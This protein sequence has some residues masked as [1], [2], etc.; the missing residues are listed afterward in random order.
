MVPATTI[1]PSACS[2]GALIEVA[3]PAATVITS[4]TMV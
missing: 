4:L 3:P 2:T 1:R